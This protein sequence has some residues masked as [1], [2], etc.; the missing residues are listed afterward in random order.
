MGLEADANP[1]DYCGLD[2]NCITETERLLQSQEDLHGKYSHDVADT[3]VVLA[4]LHWTQENQSS[5]AENCLLRAL[6]IKTQLLGFNHE[7]ILPLL[8]K[9]AEKYREK[10]ADVEAG[11]L[12][13]WRQRVF[14]KLNAQANPKSQI[15]KSISPDENAEKP[16]K[17]PGS[18][19]M[20]CAIYTPPEVVRDTKPIPMPVILT[21]LMK[22]PSTKPISY[23]CL[24]DSGQRYK[25]AQDTLF[26]GTAAVNDVCLNDATAEKFQALIKREGHDFFLF[27]QSAANSTLVNGRPMS[28]QTKL[29]WGDMITMGKTVIRVG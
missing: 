20:A 19:G 22:P 5:L 27:D 16:Q 9:L 14:A 12:D 15:Q 10:G 8:E 29:A 24:E 21:T 3:L 28:K 26:I 23:I 17:Q 1:R 6:D 4:D 25:L 2:F 18:T 11:K 13:R 7:D